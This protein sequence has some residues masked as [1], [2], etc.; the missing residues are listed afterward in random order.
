MTVILSGCAATYPI[1]EAGTEFT[2]D[3]CPPLLNCVSSESSLA[4]YRVDPIQLTEPLNETN[5]Q[6]IAAIASELPGA[7]VTKSRFG[8][9]RVTCYSTVFK[10]PDYLEILINEDQTELAVRSQSQFGLYDLNVNR[11]RVGLL[12]NQLMDRGLAE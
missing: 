12:R 6:A 2:L 8:Y 3:R 11:Q 10:F 1:P 9:L 5:W 7:N 4:L